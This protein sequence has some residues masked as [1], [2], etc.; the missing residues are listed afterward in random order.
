[1]DS[2]SID[3][4]LRRLVSEEDRPIDF[5]SRNAPEKTVFRAKKKKDASMAPDKVIIIIEVTILG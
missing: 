5:L 4:E 2:G 1:M 3:P